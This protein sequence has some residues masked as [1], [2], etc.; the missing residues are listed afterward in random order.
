MYV[1][2]R[3][4]DGSDKKKQQRTYSRELATEKEEDSTTPA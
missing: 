2:C 1:Y 3:I 4:V